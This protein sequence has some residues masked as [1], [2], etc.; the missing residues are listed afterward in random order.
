MVLSLST[1][2]VILWRNNQ[3]SLN[4]RILHTEE[5]LQSCEEQHKEAVDAIV[6]L[7]ERVGNLE[8][9]A[10]R[11]HGDFLREGESVHIK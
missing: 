3:E 4:D 9:F 1:G 7:S 10:Q 6:V 11:K 2:M 8:G 5:Q